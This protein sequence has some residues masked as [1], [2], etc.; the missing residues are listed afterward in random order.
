MQRREWESG[1]KWQVEGR[2]GSRVGFG[3]ITVATGNVWACVGRRNQTTPG[4]C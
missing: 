3:E 4:L 1:T 2:K